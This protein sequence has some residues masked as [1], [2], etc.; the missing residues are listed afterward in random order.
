M[1]SMIDRLVANLLAFLLALETGAL[2][3]CVWLAY[4]SQDG[5][6]GLTGVVIWAFAQLIILPLY[7]VITPV[8]LLLRYGVGRAFGA[9]QGAA[10]LG[11]GL[12][13]LQRV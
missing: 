13:D 5:R 11:G 3:Y 2:I 8:A 7:V 10:L 9:S 12:D 4:M 6:Y 1:S